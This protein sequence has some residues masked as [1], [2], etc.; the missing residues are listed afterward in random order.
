[1]LRVTQQQAVHL[2]GPVTMSTPF[3]PFTSDRLEPRPGYSTCHPAAG[4]LLCIARHAWAPLPALKCGE[5][6]Q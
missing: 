1:M 6:R 5:L 4:P 3:H 2:S